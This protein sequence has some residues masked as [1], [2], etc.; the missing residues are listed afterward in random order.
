LSSLKIFITGASSGLGAGSALALAAQGHT[1]TA[2]AETWAQVRTLRSAANDQGVELKVIKLDLRDNIDVEH[3]AT[4]AVGTDVLVL[5]A[6]I[7]ESGAIVDIPL[8]RVRE[9]FEINVFGHLRLVQAV[10]P[11]M[12]EKKSGKIVWLSSVAGLQAVPFLGAYGATKYAI[13]AIAGAMKLE[14]EPLGITVA[15]VAPG[16]FGTGFND[17]GAES[18][19]QWHNVDTALVPVPDMSDTL[20]NQYDPQEM[21]DAMVEIIPAKSHLYRTMRPFSTA[22]EIKETQAAQWDETV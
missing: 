11:S 6:A 2:T 5:N 13:E 1:V 15:T 4:K 22:D 10:T 14:L 16:V 19:E 3:A 17:T 20:D 18:M 7:Q 8:Q 21:I 9:S 12:V